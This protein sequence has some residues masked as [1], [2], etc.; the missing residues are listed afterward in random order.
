MTMTEAEGMAEVE[1]MMAAMGDMAEVEDMVVAE[2]G[3]ETMETAI[4]R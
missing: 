4:R 3:A 1:D 2:M